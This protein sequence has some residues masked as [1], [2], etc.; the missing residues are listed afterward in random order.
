VWF[1]FT[2]C[3][4]HGIDSSQ[5]AGVMLRTIASQKLSKILLR[6]Y[7]PHLLASCV[8]YEPNSIEQVILIN[9]LETP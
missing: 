8:T 4:I 9:I 7:R 5:D 3:K 1:R 6:E 2:D